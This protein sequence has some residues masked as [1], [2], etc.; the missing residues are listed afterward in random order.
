M[1][2]EDFILHPEKGGTIKFL[3]SLYPTGK[4][5]GFKEYPQ[6]F[7][8]QNGWIIKISILVIKVLH[9]AAK[10]MEWIGSMVE[11]LLNLLSNNGGLTGTIYRLLRGHGVIIPK[12]GTENFISF[13]G[14]LDRRLDL[15]HTNEKIIE[16]GSRYCA[17]ISVMASKLAYENE[18]LISKV[19]TKHWK[20]HFVEYFSCWNQ[21]LKTWSTQAFIFC[22][23]AE[24][25]KLV[26]IAFRGTE[27]FN[28]NDWSTDFDISLYKMEPI[29]RVHLGYLEAM[30]LA[31]RSDKDC[32]QFHLKPN[33]SNGWP[34]NVPEDT[35]KPLAYY[36][37]RARL[38][39]LLKE[40]K[41]AKFIVT[42][43][44]LGGALAVLF[45]A[46]L[47]LHNRKRLLEKMLAVYTF[48]QPR[49]GD[50]DMGNYWNKNINQPEPR[51]FR[52]VYCNDMV[53]RLPYDNNE[54]MFKHFG[55]CIYYNSFYKQKTLKE[56]PNRNFSAL[57]CIPTM[58]LNAIWE[59]IQGMMIGYTKGKHFREGWF[60]MVFRCIGIVLPGVSAHSPVNYVNAIR[61]GEPS[62]DMADTKKVR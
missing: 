30:G 21:F 23:K 17:D 51:Y 39:K 45:P 9:S 32:A 13:I 42:G 36:A 33:K 5:Q 47:L 6:H 58:Y 24:N 44:S 15:H 57:Y 53:P 61:L 34:E 50:E 8:S 29:G 35:R 43:H 2:K 38:E 22:D 41:D 49:V 40:H 55:E 54:F 16:L 27:P 62:S 1:C 3:S 25:A 37:I 12:R 31:N 11:L 52:V 56:Q 10:P 7:R 14:H 19:V 26:V 28:V 60:G 48:G 4:E 20:M 59:L 46:I 18:S